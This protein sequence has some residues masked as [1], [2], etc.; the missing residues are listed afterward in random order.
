MTEPSNDIIAS[1]RARLNRFSGR[2]R[3]VCEHSGLKYSW[4]TKFANGERGKRPSFDL[5]TR[6]GSTLDQLEPAAAPPDTANA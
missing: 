3:D 1:L 4:L 6:L 2:Y 5:I